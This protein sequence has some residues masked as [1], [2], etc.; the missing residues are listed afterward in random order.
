VAS[1]Y[2]REN[3]LEQSYLYNGKELQTDLDLDW[4][5]YGARMYDAAVGRFFTQDRFSEKYLDFSPYQYAANNPIIYID[6]NGDSVWIA[7][8]VLHITGAVY[9][10]TGDHNS[11]SLASDLTSALGKKLQAAFA[12]AGIEM[13]LDIQIRGVESMDDVSSGDNLWAVRE[14]ANEEGETVNYSYVN[15]YKRNS[16]GAA[17]YGNTANINTNTPS[18]LVN[19]MIHEGGH[20]FGLPHVKDRNGQVSTSTNNPMGY[21]NPYTTFFFGSWGD[22]RDGNFSGEQAR[23]I[24]NAVSDNRVNFHGKRERQERSAIPKRNPTTWQKAKNF[25]GL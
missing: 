21:A 24:V 22:G 17:I 11:S 1:S 19:T 9:D 8:G 13:E 18:S 10:A 6:V 7:D 23:T 25:F 5:D 15:Q 12:E 3:S 14:I 2:Q 4:Y 20:M 16:D